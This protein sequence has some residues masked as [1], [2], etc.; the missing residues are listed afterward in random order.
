M[1]KEWKLTE[2]EIRKQKGLEHLK[3]WELTEAKE[4]IE[5]IS[6]LLINILKD[7]LNKQTKKSYEKE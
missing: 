3:D 7:E 4:T 5:K 2:E 6:S 1:E